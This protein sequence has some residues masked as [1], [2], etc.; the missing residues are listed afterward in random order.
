MTRDDPERADDGDDRTHFAPSG[1]GDPTDSRLFRGVP[2]PLL[3]YE[4]DGEAAVVRGLNPAFERTFSVDRSTAA[5]DPVADYLLVDAVAVDPGPIGAAATTGTGDDT[6]RADG[7]PD[8][9]PDAGRVLSRLDDGERVTVATRRDAD[10]E[11]RTFRLRAAPLPDASDGVCIVYTD[12]TEYCRLVREFEARVDRL[13]RFI[14]VAAHD[15]RNPL[16]VAKIR[17]EAARDTAEPVHFEKAEAALERIS[18]IARDVLSVGSPDPDPTEGTAIATVAEAAWS[19]V[20]TGDAALVVA[21]DLP[22]V[23]ADDDLLRHLFENLFR[24]AVEHGSAIG[25]RSDDGGPPDEDAPERGGGVTATVGRLPDGFFVAD[26]GRGVPP[27]ER[28]QVFAPGYSTA[29]DNTGL[30]LAI[31]EQIAE[32]HGWRVALTASDGGGARFEFTGLD[33]EDPA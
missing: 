17:V 24:N 33:P 6:E 4:T 8:A 28:E 29:D 5:G 11:R 1:D 27:E 10:G 18:R 25:R 9:D 21:D 31:V 30:G 22:T 16:D 12:V 2:D 15:L 20:D 14:D 19:T 32:A 23:E 3:Y 7:A 13:E 26:D